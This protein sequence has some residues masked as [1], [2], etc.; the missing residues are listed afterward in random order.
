MGE[1][2]GPDYNSFLSCLFVP[3]VHSGLDTYPE[4][5][6]GEISSFC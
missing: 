6:E 4:I 3:S 5:C 1:T 2:R